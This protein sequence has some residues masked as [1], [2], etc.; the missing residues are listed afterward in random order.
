MEKYYK[1]CKDKEKSTF[2]KVIGN[3]SIVNIIISFGLFFGGLLFLLYYLYI[4]FM[5]S[6]NNFT[7]FTYLLF[8]MAIVGMFL[9]FILISLFV[10]HAF[11]YDKLFDNE[12]KKIMDKPMFIYSMLIVPFVMLVYLIKE[13]YFNEFEYGAVLYGI[14]L[15]FAIVLP[16]ICCFNSRSLSAK[17]RGERI[18]YVVMQ[19][20]ISCYSTII[21]YIIFV[22]S[23]QTNVATNED[24][25][26]TFFLFSVVIIV[27]NVFI[28]DDKYHKKPLLK[29]ILVIFSFFLLMFIFRTYALIPSVV[30]HQF[31]LGNFMIASITSKQ[32]SCKVLLDLNVSKFKISSID[33]KNKTCTVKGEICILSSIGNTMLWQIDN[34]RTIRLSSADFSGMVSDTFDNK[35]CLIYRHN[36]KIN[37]SKEK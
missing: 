21:I 30:M 5:P 14:L 36:R 6:L 37:E 15:I 24:A 32:A 33:I 16:S 22:L 8:A 2:N 20:I 7:D 25:L 10:F 13:T 23:K 12:M 31:K 17:I 27:I 3:S 28:L 19:V 34:N 29:F 35:R 26:V 1:Y 4:G 11:S 18:L 9:F